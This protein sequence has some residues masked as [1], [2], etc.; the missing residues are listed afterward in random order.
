MKRKFA[1][2][3]KV[4]HEYKLLNKKNAE[5]RTGKRGAST[6]YFDNSATTKISSEVLQTYV[7]VSENYF[8]NPSSLH[9]LGETSSH[10]LAQSRKQVADL[11]GVDSRE[12]YFTSGGTE[13]DNWV[14]KGTAIEKRR[15]GNHLITTAVEHPAVRETMEQ[16]ENLGW[17]V[18]YLPVNEEGIVSVVDLKQAIRKDTVLISVMAVNNETGSIQPIDEIG[19]LLKEYP[20]IHFH[21]DAVQAIGKMDL[22]LGLE[23]RIDM[24]VFSGH[25][26]H[27]P[28]GVGFV[29]VKKGRQLAPLLSGG[30][31]E[32]NRRSGTENLPAI[33]AMA[34]ALRLLL[35]QAEQKQ[36]K[37]SQLLLSLR[38]ELQPLKHVTIFTPEQSAPHI[39]C[40][41]IKGI[42][43]EVTVHALE[44]NG[45]FVSTT[46]AC[47]SRNGTESSTLL[48]MKVAKENAE[49]AIRVSL[50]ENNTEEEMKT[51]V[52]QFKNVYQ[53][54]QKLNS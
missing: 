46:S 18:T 2:I 17:D 39:L 34:K 51:F 37:I 9:G 30:G 12:I 35:D 3:D 16:L 28:R 31:Q 23:S 32:T 42:R 47:S 13:G 11:M 7:K 38:K 45:I 36:Q 15:Y 20:S 41:G 48:A 14:I 43:G 49:T 19:K 1:I 22:H 24:A 8:G 44:E 54:F 25:K 53:K 27:A 5:Q 33:A 50:S 10:L 21:V 4:C 29:Y 40:F 26:F 52:Q 6:I